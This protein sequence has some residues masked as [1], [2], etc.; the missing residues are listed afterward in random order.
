M[1]RGPV[2]RAVS[3]AEKRVKGSWLRRHYAGAYNAGHRLVDSRGLPTPK[4]S[5]ASRW[6]ERV[7]RTQTDRAA[8]ARK[9]ARLLDEYRRSQR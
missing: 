3:P 6:G 9:G 4:A 7:P 2:R 1:V 8:L 5:Q